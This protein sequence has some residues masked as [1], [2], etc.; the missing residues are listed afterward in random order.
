M[1]QRAADMF[2]LAESVTEPEYTAVH[3]RAM[4][5]DVPWWL[6]ANQPGGFR[7]WMLFRVR[8]HLYGFDDSGV[9]A[10]GLL[11]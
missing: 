3:L 7:A 11:H 6:A 9:A 5:E 2:G 4:V 1:S 10:D 8:E